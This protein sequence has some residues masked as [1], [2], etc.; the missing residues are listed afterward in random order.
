MVSGMSRLSIL[1]FHLT[2]F[3]ILAGAGCEENYLHEPPFGEIRDTTYL[4]TES[5]FYFDD[6]PVVSSNIN[7]Y[8]FSWQI[9][10]SVGEG[11]LL[12][13]AKRIFFVESPQALDD[14]VVF[15]DTD[16]EVGDTIYKYSGSQYHILINKQP[17]PYL[18]EQV[19]FVLRRSKKGVRRQ[20]ERSVWVVS[21]QKGILAVTNYDIDLRNGQVTLDMVGDDSYFREPSFITLLKLYD[22]DTA[23]QVDRDRNII[24]EFNKQ[25]GILKSKDFLAR[26]D[27]YSYEFNQRSMSRLTEFSI[28]LENNSVR[29]VAGDSCFVFSESLELLRSASCSAG[30]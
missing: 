18:N 28:E 24:Y 6:K 15:L 30:F 12:K 7:F 5:W 1:T 27:L 9:L 10:E 22:F 8:P 13:S 29:L 11:F 14:K 26:K 19:Y 3:L 25:T 2:A 17:D 21:T 4:D 23:Y 16:I 20:E